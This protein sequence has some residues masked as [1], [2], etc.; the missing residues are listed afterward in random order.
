MADA[1]QN[2]LDRM[3]NGVQAANTVKQVA[4]K[5]NPL[6]LFFKNTRKNIEDTANTLN[7]LLTATNE[8]ITTYNNDSNE[9]RAAAANLNK[10]V[11]NIYKLLLEDKKK[12]ETNII[13]NDGIAKLASNAES[14]E[15]K[16]DSAMIAAKMADSLTKVL[17][18]VA[19]VSAFFDK[20]LPIIIVG[21]LLLYGFVVGWLNG[22][23][24]DFVVALGAAVIGLFVA[25]V[26]FQISKTMILLGIQ[27]ACEW[28][29]VAIASQ[30]VAV[31]LI[32]IGIIVAAFL[33]VA[34]VIAV[35]VVGAVLVTLA[36]TYLITKAMKGMVDNM[37]Q[38]I[39]DA[40]AAQLSKTEEMVKDTIDVIGNVIPMMTSSML[41]MSE[42][43]SNGLDAV[44]NHLGDSFLRMEHTMDGLASEMS[45]IFNGLAASIISSALFKSV[46]K[47]KEEGVD[48]KTR[49]QPIHDTLHHIDTMIAQMAS[50]R[51]EQQ[52]R[53]ARSS[54]QNAEYLNS[55]S[56]TY[57][58]FDTKDGNKFL[59]DTAVIGAPEDKVTGETLAAM[60]TAIITELRALTAALQGLNLQVTVREPSRP[61]SIFDSE[62]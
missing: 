54:Y 55:Y 21:G 18:P 26:A 30:P 60:Q 40:F 22:S 42:T 1:M 53:I 25:F 15:P 44:I 47:A 50:R 33:V 41:A 43:L 7:L 48:L 5:L 16:L 62:G 52:A 27:I 59:H 9:S 49:L 24:M 38:N 17:N 23:V 51:V 8:F 45:K 14:K 28:L 58:T 32:G 34:A 36:A 46:E 11:S 57:N 29:K 6:N 61:Y 19:L 3:A 2:Y 10:L 56:N 13:K 37:V 20:F 4:E 31:A 35:A 12:V 39:T